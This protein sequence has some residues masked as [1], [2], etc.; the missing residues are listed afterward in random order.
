MTLNIMP[1]IQK[2]IVL[3]L[4]MIAGICARKFKIIDQ[5]ST[6]VL[7]SF[8]VNISNPLLIIYSFQIDFDLEKLKTGALIFLLSA[9]MHIVCTVLSAVFFSRVKEIK[10]KSVY[11]YGLIFAN[12]GF[13]GFPVLMAIFGDIGLFYGAFFTAFFN[14]FCWTYGVYIMNRHSDSQ[15]DKFQVPWKKI[16]LNAGLIAIIIGILLFILKIK[17]PSPVFDAFKMVGDMAFPLSM[18]I[19][20]SLVS[21]LDFKKLIKSYFLYFYSFIK[22]IIL[23]LLAIAVCYILKLPSLI[24]NI[25]VVMAAMPTA[26]NTAVFT[27]IYDGDSPLAAQCVGITTLFSVATIPLIMYIANYV[28]SLA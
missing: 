6:K 20:G 26:T 13:M 19:I 22:L 14:L 8:L 15:S 28:F 1:V 23:P 5:K 11:E 24:S 4:V 17:L 10:Q 7:S 12:Y 25:C 18:I 2:V 16:F 21:V 3:F 9:V 27:E